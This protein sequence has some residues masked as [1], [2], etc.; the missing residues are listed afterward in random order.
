MPKEILAVV[1]ESLVKLTFD[2]D[3]LLT[4]IGKRKINEL[5]I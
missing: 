1:D 4:R 2:N 5:S 3:V